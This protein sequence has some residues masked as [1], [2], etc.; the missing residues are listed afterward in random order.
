MAQLITR[1]YQEM[2]GVECGVLVVDC[3]AGQAYIKIH[4]EMVK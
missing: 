3:P 1:K 2:E 4:T